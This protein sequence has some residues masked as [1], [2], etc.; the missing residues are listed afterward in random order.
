MSVSLELC[1]SSCERGK[2]LAYL[3]WSKRHILR[4]WSDV[5]S[6]SRPEFIETKTRSSQNQNCASESLVLDGLCTER[7]N[8]I[9]TEKKVFN[10]DLFHQV[11]I[12]YL[13]SYSNTCGVFLIKYI[14]II[15]IDTTLRTFGYELFFSHC[16]H[17]KKNLQMAATDFHK[18][19]QCAHW[20]VM[21]LS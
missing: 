6:C 8:N 14:Q 3:W 15:I 2:T 10:C 17:Y 5:N 16:D 4:K 18:M 13:T 1:S 9:K 21:S 7:G 20:C 12:E 19:W 11:I